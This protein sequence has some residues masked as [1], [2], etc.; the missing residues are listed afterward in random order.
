LWADDDS[1]ESGTTLFRLSTQNKAE[2]AQWVR[3][4]EFACNP[5]D[6]IVSNISDGVVHVNQVILAV[7]ID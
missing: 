3:S 2:A 6:S 5:P 4:L 1:E 7:T